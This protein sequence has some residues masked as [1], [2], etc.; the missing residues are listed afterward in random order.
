MFELYI[1]FK[2]KQSA[3][4]AILDSKGFRKFPAYNIFAKVLEGGG[5]VIANLYVLQSMLLICLM[6]DLDVLV[7]RSPLKLNQNC[8][9]NKH[10]DG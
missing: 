10:N 9:I 4:F 7:K 8:H 1:N 6:Y 3:N 5:R 2:K